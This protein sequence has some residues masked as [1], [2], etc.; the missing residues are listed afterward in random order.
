[1]IVS[2][3]KTLDSTSQNALQ[4]CQ[5]LHKDK[6]VGREPANIQKRTFVTKQNEDAD[7]NHI[8]NGHD[9]KDNMSVNMNL[10]FLVTMFE[11]ICLS[12]IPVYGQKNTEDFRK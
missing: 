3:L 12:C 10:F 8:N 11:P 2:T 9:S 6:W 4:N 1:M 5:N 7:E